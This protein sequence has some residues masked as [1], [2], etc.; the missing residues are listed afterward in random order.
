[1]AKGGK[2]ARRERSELRFVPRPV[3]T[4]P[5]VYAAGALA[6]LLL[7][8]GAWAQWLRTMLTPAEAS[9]PMGTWILAAGIVVLG[10]AI[11]LG[12][13][14]EPTLRVGDGGVALE[15]NGVTRLPWWGVES[16]VYDGVGLAVVARGKGEGGGDVVVQA[17]VKGHPQAAAWIVREARRRVP[18]T[19]QI[20][21]EVALP[22]VREGAGERLALE[23][24][25]IVG[26]RCAESGSIIAFE[27]DGRVCARCERVFHKDHVPETCECGGVMA[28]TK[29]SDVAGEAEL[30]EPV[31]DA[32]PREVTA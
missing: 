12:T 29:G 25:Q 17:R 11:W 9:L 31:A 20:G 19:V 8:A 4:P 21:D 7:G 2:K 30:R 28:A 1:M 27:P 18:G 15:K 13:S 22:A 10:V 5:V 23:Q 3:G 16:V 24:L 14:G 26:R 32:A 6:A